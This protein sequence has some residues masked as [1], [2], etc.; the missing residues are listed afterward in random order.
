MM[1]LVKEARIL[2]VGVRHSGKQFEKIRHSI[3]GHL[4]LKL[5]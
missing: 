1:S 2:V 4:L 3:G 5:A